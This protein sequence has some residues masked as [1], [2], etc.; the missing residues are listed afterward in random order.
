[1]RYYILKCDSVE[2]LMGYVNNHIKKGWKLQGGVSMGRN[3]EYIQAIIKEKND[4]D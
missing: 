4:K 2:A 1:M 3:G